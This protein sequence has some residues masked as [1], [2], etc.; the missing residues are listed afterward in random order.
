MDLAAGRA[1]LLSVC[2]PA[3]LP[4]QEGFWRAHSHLQRLA[5]QQEP[6][7]SLQAWLRPSCLGGKRPPS[8]GRLGPS[9][10]EGERSPEGVCTQAAMR[11]ESE[12]EESKEEREREEQEG[13]RVGG[14][15]KRKG[16]KRRVGW[17]GRGRRGRREIVRGYG[18]GPILT[19]PFQ[20]LPRASW[21]RRPQCW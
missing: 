1:Y 2:R 4:H 21:A 6:L 17:E 15:R 20:V 19:C 13:R 3:L 16:R 11:W 5:G 7:E 12:E 8:G 14:S 18:P 9:G 10:S